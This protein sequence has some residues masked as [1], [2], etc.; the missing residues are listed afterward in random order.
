MT[1]KGLLGGESKEMEKNELKILLSAF[2]ESSFLGESTP[3]NVDLDFST[4]NNMETLMFYWDSIGFGSQPSTLIEKRI[5]EV[6]PAVNDMEILM[7][8]Y[9]KTDSGS[10]LEALTEKRMTEVL[11]AADDMKTLMS[12]WDKIDLE[13]EV[14]ELVEKR[15]AEVLPE[16]L[17]TISDMEILMFCWHK[18][19]SESELEALLEKRISEVLSEV[20]LPTVSIDAVPEWF[21]AMIRDVDLPSFLS[22]K[23]RQKAESLL[24]EL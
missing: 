4:V 16:L 9:G 20:L 15:V 5:A 10:E 23:L 14:R 17:P 13:S 1:E 21:I 8:F 12:Y 22:E 18:I 3:T 19:S 24:Q 7:S 11:S 6:L 2:L